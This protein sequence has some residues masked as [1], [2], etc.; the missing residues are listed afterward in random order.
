M[1]EGTRTKKTIFVGG[2]GDDVDERI[3]LESFSTFGDIIDVQ[4]PPAATNPSQQTE[5]KHRGFGFVT[6]SSPADAQDAID[7]MDLNELNG[8]VLK[9]NLARQ[10]KGPTQGLGN[11]AIWE[12]EDW[13]QQYAKPLNQ[14]G[15]AALRAKGREG[16]KGAEDVEDAEKDEDEDAMKV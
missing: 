6:F 2:I 5:A 7:N 15:G 8:R 3:L 1:E 10:F 12:S 11:R 9:V 13:L 16:S 14:S 4:L